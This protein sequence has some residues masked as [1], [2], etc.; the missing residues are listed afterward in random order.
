[1]NETSVNKFVSQQVGNINEVIALDKQVRK[2]T[3]T[4]LAEFNTSE[5]L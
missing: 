5:G 3:Q 2:F 4:L 1:M